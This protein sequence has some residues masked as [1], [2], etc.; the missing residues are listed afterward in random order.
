[1]DLVHHFSGLSNAQK[2]VATETLDGG[3]LPPSCTSHSQ[4][5]P[6]TVLSTQLVF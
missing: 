4:P 2:S 5:F 3:V 6:A 1:M